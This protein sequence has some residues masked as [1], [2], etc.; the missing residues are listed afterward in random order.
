MKP[1]KPKE[2]KWYLTL[3]WVYFFITLTILAVM[4]WFAPRAASMPDTPSNAV[5]TL[6][7]VFQTIRIGTV[8]AYS[9]E[10]GQTD[11]TP[12]ITAS[13]KSVRNSIIANNCLKFGTEVGVYQ[14]TLRN[15]DKVFKVYDVEDRMN[16]RFD[17]SHYDIWNQNKTEALKFGKQK[18]EIRIL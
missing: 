6:K 13:G 17:C 15:G 4:I 16:R 10:I 5:G 1:Y 9:S 8:T 12:F 3:I 2:S 7:S 14:G 18:L 11:T